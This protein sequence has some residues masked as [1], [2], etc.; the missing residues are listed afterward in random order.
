LIIFYFATKNE[1]APIRPVGKF[2]SVEALVFGTW[3]QSVCISML[4]QMDLIPHYHSGN[5]F[6]QGLLSEQDA[7]DLDEQGGGS[8]VTE[9]TSEDVA[10]GLQDY[11][12]CIEMFIA[13]IVHAWVF[14]HTEYSPEA[15]EARSRALNQ[16]PNKHWN[17]RLGRK[18]KDSDNKSSY[19]GA[20]NT[21]SSDEPL[22]GTN[23]INSYRQ[24]SMS[25]EDDDL[26]NHPLDAMTAVSTDD[27]DDFD[28]AEHR[29]LLEPVLS[30]GSMEGRD[31]GSEDFSSASSESDSEEDEDQDVGIELVAPAVVVRKKQGF[32][33]ALLDSSI[34]QD[35][36]DNA[37]GIIK[38]DY[39]VEKKTLL[40]HAATSD[41]YDLF[42][43]VTPRKKVVGLVPI[44]DA[45]N[46]V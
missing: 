10:K 32:V 42:S 37:V 46:I 34:P 12:I 30:E 41:S 8:L 5:G 45:L 20:T 26:M 3:W 4:Y 35:L 27:E 14:P 19:S 22:P 43:R 17:K 9:W 29:S 6:T 15:V 2:L 38:G 21:S 25:E 24:R 11:L 18:W 31:D 28:F 33:R 39:V 16:T 40:H 7:M 13:A 1:L 36:R 44:T 23:N